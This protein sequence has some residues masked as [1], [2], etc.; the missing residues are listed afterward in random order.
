MYIVGENKIDVALIPASQ[1]ATAVTGEYFKMDDAQN[2][3]FA[4]T[5]TG[6]D[7]D[8][9]S[10]LQVVQATDAEGTD[11]KNVTGATVDLSANSGAT[12]ATVQSDDPDVDDTVTINGIVFTAKTSEDTDDREFDQSGTDAQTATSLANCVND[13][14]N[15]VPGVSA[16]ASTDTVT[17]TVDEP[18]ELALDVETSD[19][20]NLVVTATITGIVEIRDGALDTDDNFGYAALTVDN[21]SDVVCGAMAIRGNLRYSAPDQ[22]GAGLQIG[23]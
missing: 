2:I 4:F 20:T 8:E 13:A 7:N 11:S 12:E 14:D 3:A 17:L 5:A 21:D 9:G 16:T 19:N 1:G 22:V 18:G 15:G 10:S 6:V 23:V